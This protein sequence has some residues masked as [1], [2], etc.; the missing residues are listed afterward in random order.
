MIVQGEFKGKGM[1]GRA[2]DQAGGGGAVKGIPEQRMPQGISMHTHLVCATGGGKSSQERIAIE[3]F[4]N[5]ESGLGWFALAVID[6][7]AMGMPDIDAQRMAGSVFFP[8][9]G[10]DHEGVIDFVCLMVLELNIQLPMR[11]SVARENHQPAGDFVQAV[12]YPKATVLR[13]ERFNQGAF[14]FSPS[15]GDG[16]KAGG[17]IGYQY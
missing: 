12:Y 10:T 2:G 11:G 17:L 3:A 14:I 5:L 4:Q 6:N 15:A 16:G 1:Q 9:R 8:D 13:L 7:C